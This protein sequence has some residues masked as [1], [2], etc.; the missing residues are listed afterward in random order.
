MNIRNKSAVMWLAGINVFAFILQMIF[1]PWLTSNFLLMQGDIFTRPWIL[2]THMFLHGSISH[3]LFNMYA[4]VIFGSILEQKIGNKRFLQLYFLAGIIAGFVASFAYPRSLGASGAIMGVLAALIILMPDL[5]V[6]FF[7]AIPMP[8]WVAGVVWALLDLA[9]VF[10]P[11]GVAN[12]AHLVGMAVGILYGLY[13]KNMKGRFQ[14]S[15]S[16]KTHLSEKDI[17]DMF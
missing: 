2:V 7:F 4:L 5:R 9:G 17:R 6:L 16:S 13:I 3:L 14:K 12:L 10:F 15:L 1:D 11:H 8:F